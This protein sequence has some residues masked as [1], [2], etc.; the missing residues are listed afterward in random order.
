[1]PERLQAREFQLNGFTVCRAL[2]TP[3]EA[4]RIRHRVT[5]YI[6]M[7]MDGEPGEDIMRAEGDGEII[8]L[9]KLD[10]RDNFFRKLKHDSRLR[11]AA[12]ALL[13]AENRPLFVDFINKHRTAPVTP[14]H[15]DAYIFTRLP[16]DSLTMWIALDRIERENGC[17]SYV[18]GS[19][20][21]GYRPHD[22]QPG[23][24][25]LLEYTDRD[26]ELEVAVDAWPG[27]VVVHHSFTVH[28]SN[29]NLCGRPRW[30]LAIP[31]IRSDSRVIS[32][33]RWMALHEA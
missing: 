28:R 30:A 14:P 25:R 26:R 18:R 4:D 31:F 27:D 8:V 19:H 9:A 22:P 24:N 16:S 23:P 2:F 10:R 32:R 1:M 20:W 29:E 3:D 6:A 11:T 21:H 15:Q 7:R 17:L 5:Q 33:E 13:N 12:R